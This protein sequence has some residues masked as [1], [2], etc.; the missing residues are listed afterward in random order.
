MAMKYAVMD[1]RMKA[2]EETAKG[3]AALL[4]ARELQAQTLSHLQQDID[5]LKRG[6]GFI[7]DPK[8]RPTVDGEYGS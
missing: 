3:I 1:D 2:M 4:T 6:R 7:R 5:D 8:N